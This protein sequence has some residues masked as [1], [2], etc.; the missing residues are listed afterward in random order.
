MV[1]LNVWF[2]VA[3]IKGRPVRIPVCPSFSKAKIV[4]CFGLSKTI[5]D[6]MGYSCVVSLKSYKFFWRRN[7]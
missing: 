4:P 2:S 5:T 3:K 7:L 6:K 1:C